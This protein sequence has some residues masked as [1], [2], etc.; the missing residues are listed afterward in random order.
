M[1][2]I[3]LRRR[4]WRRINLECIEC[5]ECLASG[6]SGEPWLTPAKLWGYEQM[7]KGRKTQGPPIPNQVQS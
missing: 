6:R 1:H 3:R 5:N 2:T 7:H 4:W